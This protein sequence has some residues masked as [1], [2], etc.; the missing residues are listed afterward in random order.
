MSPE[1]QGRVLDRLVATG[2][3]DEPWALIV[4]AAMESAELLDGF[5]DKKATVAPPQQSDVAAIVVSEPP[6]AYT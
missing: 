5:L 2:K 1:V 3:S 4:L 6:G